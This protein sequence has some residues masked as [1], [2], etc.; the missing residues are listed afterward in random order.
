MNHQDS[1]DSGS[2]PQADRLRFGKVYL[3]VDRK[4]GLPDHMEGEFSLGFFADNAAFSIQFEAAPNHEVTLPNR[5]SIRMKTAMGGRPGGMP[6][7]MMGPDMGPGMTETSFEFDRTYSDYQFALKF[8]PG[9]FDSNLEP[10]PRP[11]FPPRGTGAQPTASSDPFEEISLLPNRPASS[12]GDESTTSLDEVVFIQG[13]S[14]ERSS[15]EGDDRDV[16]RDILGLERGMGGPDGGGP[17]GPG[18][19]GGPGPGRFGGGRRMAFGGSRANRIQGSL[20]AGYSGSALDARPYS[21][22]GEDS[23]SPSYQ[24]WNAGVSLGGPLPG[25]GANVYRRRGQFFVNFDTS[26]GNQLN[27]AFASVPTLLERQGDFS[28]TVYQ[29]G[30]L[31][32]Q[33]VQIFNP[34]TGEAYAGGKIP[35]DQINSAALGL[36]S[37][38]PDPNRTDSYLNYFS[39]QSLGNHSDR[40]NTQVSFPIA[41]NWHLSTGYSY[42]QSASDGF[43]VFP[44][45]SSDRKGNGHNVNLSLNT[46]IRPGLIHNTR[47]RYN[48]NDSRSLNPFAFQNDVSAELGF[49][50][51]SPSP[52]DYGLPSLSFTNYTGLN[53]GSSS[54]NVRETTSINDSWM[55]VWNSHFM[56]V[57]FDY[58]W[59]RYNLLGSPNGS[60]SLNLAGIATSR[61]DESGQI[62]PGTGYDLSDLLLGWAQSSQ[63]QY[64]NP[65]H[66]LRGR[67]FSLFLNDNWRAHSRFTLQWGIRYDFVSPYVEKYDR[68]SNLDIGP[69]FSSAATVVPGSSGLDLASYPRGMVNSD[70]NNLAPRLG[71]AFRLKSGRRAAILRAEY[72]VFYP[73]EAYSSFARELVAQPPFGYTVQ[74]TAEGQNFLPLTD[75]FATGVVP[76]AANTYAV[77]PNYRLQTVQN[78]GLSIQQALPAGLFTSL[79]YVGSRGTGLELLRAPNRLTAAGLLIPDAAQFLFLTPGASSTFHGMQLLVMRRMQAGFS[80]SAQYL[81]GKSLDNASTIGGQG[82]TVP[83]NDS[84]LASEKGLSSF[85]VRH[86]FSLKSIWELPFGDRHRWLRDPGLFN[87]LMK[88]WYLS[89]T[90]SANTGRPY[91]ARILGN[92]VNNSGTGSFS[93]ERANAAGISPDLSGNER[94][95]AMWFNTA[96]FSLPEP[97]TF[98]DAGRNTI[99]GP[100]AWTV[101]LSIH[102]SIRLDENGRRLLL[103]V[104]SQNVLN[105]VNYTSI[106]T[107]VNSRGFGQ[108]TSAGMMRSVQMEVRLSF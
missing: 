30:P 74:A 13:A 3:W 19:P 104:R 45:L 101:D 50:R 8:E 72:G 21:L 18:G 84:N 29:S 99:T 86:Q 54:I 70:K 97:G 26:R 103:S 59:L 77:D 7:G 55:V 65:D 67:Q 80:F 105:H 17:E 36:L 42:S 64:G 57:G 10:V 48:R 107:V 14:K 46:P 37:Y 6:G 108:V 69:G 44:S 24:K 83:Q 96:A 4:S 56:R 39:Q 68:I 88:D 49:A 82:R 81:L 78:W 12:G 102:R 71:L 2:I 62:L 41:G 53:D 40:L 34:A 75:A 76:V 87:I 38:F 22:T 98:G 58:S 60:G 66:Y 94:T 11:G 79:G 89:W 100:G 16:L 91:T 15:R 35:T 106:D 73:G 51:T 25:Q 5:M 92:Q 33:A 61:Y 85:D 63:I 93:S 90:F 32:G 47:I 1:P 95:T 52:I 23:Q 27:S 20:Q 9:F 28:E 43:N 31:A